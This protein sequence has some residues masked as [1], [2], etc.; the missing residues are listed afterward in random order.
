MGKEDLSEE[1]H[2]EDVYKTLNKDYNLPK[3]CLYFIL[4]KG[5]P[6][7]TVSEVCSYV[8]NQIYLNAELIIISEIGH[9]S[10]EGL[11]FIHQNINFVKYIEN[12]EN[13]SIENILQ[14]N[15]QAKICVKITLESIK[16]LYFVQNIYEERYMD[17]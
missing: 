9:L 4:Q 2:E 17:K 16:D 12:N 14:E 5:M 10:P 3:I 7:D 1:D 13:E 11:Q 15:T 6:S 8:Y